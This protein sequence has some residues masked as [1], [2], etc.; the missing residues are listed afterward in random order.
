M[1]QL[2][3]YSIPKDSCAHGASELFYFLQ[4]NILRSGGS[5]N[6]RHLSQGMSGTCALF[7]VINNVAQLVHK[8]NYA[9]NRTKTNIGKKNT[10]KTTSLGN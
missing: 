9:R 2:I 6:N 10:R 1:M 8:L 7:V 3:T 5:K 4:N